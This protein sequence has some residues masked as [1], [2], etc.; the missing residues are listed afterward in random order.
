MKII[1]HLDSDQ[2]A[3]ALLTKVSLPGYKVANITRKKNTAIVEYEK[4]TTK[5]KVANVTR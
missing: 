3:V 4:I 1:Y 2:G 5:I